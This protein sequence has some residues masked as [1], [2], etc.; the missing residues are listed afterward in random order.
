[1]GEDKGWAQEGIYSKS[2]GTNIYRIGKIIR[3]ITLIR[4]R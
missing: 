4:N 1:M 3:I 2:M